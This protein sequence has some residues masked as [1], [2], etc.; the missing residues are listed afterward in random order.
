DRALMILVARHII[1]V[2]QPLNP[3]RRRP[4]SV[5]NGVEPIVSDSNSASQPSDLRVSW[6]NSVSERLIVFAA[7]FNLG[8][9]RLIP[10]AL[11]RWR[12][13]LFPQ[14]NLEIKRQQNREDRQSHQESSAWINGRTF[15]TASINPATAAAFSTPDQRRSIIVLSGLVFASW[16][17]MLSI[18]TD[19]SSFCSS[20]NASDFAI[21]PF[22]SVKLWCSA[23]NLAFTTLPSPSVIILL[24]VALILIPSYRGAC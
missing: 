4:N 9:A 16:S 2:V 24:P 13:R 14:C 1:L 8:V 21:A 12:K 11:K 23:S 18:S 20:L 6:L 15:S 10:G 19:T 5:S 22:N 3:I 7:R 17:F